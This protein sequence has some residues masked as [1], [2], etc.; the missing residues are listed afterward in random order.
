M[1]FDFKVTTWERIRVPKEKEQEVLKA[2][3]DGKVTCANDIY[4]IC[5]DAE[6][7]EIDGL[8]SEQMSIEENDGQSTIEVEEDGETLYQNGE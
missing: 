3:E 4:G 5:D 2:I 8:A 1:D 6:L 7:H